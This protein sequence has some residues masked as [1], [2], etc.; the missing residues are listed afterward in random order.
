MTRVLALNNANNWESIYSYNATAG[1]LSD[2]SYI[3]IPPVIAPVFIESD[4]IAVYT[5]TNVP[6]GRKWFRGGRV[7]QR[8]NTGITVGGNPDSTASVQYLIL[9]EINI[10]FFPKLTSSYS[11]KFYFPTYFKNI[12]LQVWQ[13]T[14]VDDETSDIASAEQFGNINFKLNQLNS[15]LDSILGN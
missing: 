6:S 14:G 2:N 7:E 12:E 3:P 10:I 9:K 13:Y 4:I 1:I 15:K 5:N 8:L 11:L